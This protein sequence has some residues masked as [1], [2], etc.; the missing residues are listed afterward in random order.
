[1]KFLIDYLKGV[2]LGAGAILPG[3]SSG[4][5]CV[6]FGIYEK[7]IDSVLNIFKDFKTNFKF[8]LPIGLGGV[9]GILLFG[10]ILK[11]L[12]NTYP[13]PTKFAFIGLIIGCIPILFK[14]ANSKKGFRL[15]YLIYLIITFLLGTLSILLEQFLENNIIYEVS[16][17]YWLLI[18]AGFFM[19]IG[20]VVPGVSSSVIL[21]SFGVYYEY[22]DAVSTINLS[23]LIPLAIG[24][25]VGGY[26]FLK[27]IKYLLE[28]HFSET[29]YAIIGFVLGSVLILY[30]GFSFN[31]VGLVSILCFACSF[32][33]SLQF[34]KLE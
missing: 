16:N 9:T 24:V 28:H 5:L 32:L 7:L 3:I 15:H 20:I 18:V 14:K 34:E 26:L 27:I 4:V 17:N 23:I 22:L 6:I 1:L 29:F 19:S 31:I 10:K 30:P 12:F 13:M 8:L 21:M 25:I 11:Y 33:V 2:A